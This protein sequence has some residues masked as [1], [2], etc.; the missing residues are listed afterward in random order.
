MSWFESGP[1]TD[2]LFHN[3]TVV[4]TGAVGDVVAVAPSATKQGTVHRN[5]RVTGNVIHMHNGSRAAVVRAR[6]IAGLT[7]AGN[8]IYSPGRPLSAAELVAATNCSGVVTADNTVIT[9][10]AA[11][12]I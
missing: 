2:V 7:L 8:V 1:V 12:R 11:H 5:V 4:R 9:S 3:N 6:S 10:G